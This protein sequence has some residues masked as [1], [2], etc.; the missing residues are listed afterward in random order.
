M[1]TDESLADWK[2]YQMVALKAVVMAERSAVTTETTSAALLAYCLVAW[3]VYSMAAQ[4]DESSAEWR[5]D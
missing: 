3:L 1:Q 2:A 4:T 5:A